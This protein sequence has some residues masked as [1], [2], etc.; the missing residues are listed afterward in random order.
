MENG[1]TVQ[2]EIPV[3]SCGEGG[4]H[5]ALFKC[6]SERDE[7][8]A[9]QGGSDLPLSAGIRDMDNFKAYNDAYGFSNGDRMITGRSPTV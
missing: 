9:V 7:G 2:K 8:Y 6:G 5:K 3:G 4:R 1:R